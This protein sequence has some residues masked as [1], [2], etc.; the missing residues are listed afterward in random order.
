MYKVY[1]RDN[2]YLLSV[3]TLSGGFSLALVAF[4]SSFLLDG[5]FAIVSLAYFV[6]LIATARASCRQFSV[7]ALILLILF[8]IATSLMMTFGSYGMTVRG[9]SLMGYSVYLD[10]NNKEN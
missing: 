9:R 2:Y 4:T 8:S 3:M 6:Y 10:N 1:L 5:I 7:I